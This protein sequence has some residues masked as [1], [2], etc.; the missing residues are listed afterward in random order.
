MLVTPTPSPT[1]LPLSTP[2]PDVGAL[3]AQI[4]ALQA[5]QYNWSVFVGVALL[6]LLVLIVF[7]R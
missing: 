4:A 6:G 2:T 1:P 3:A 5:A 7:R